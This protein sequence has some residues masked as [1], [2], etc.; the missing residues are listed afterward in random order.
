MNRYIILTLTT[1]FMGCSS[2]SSYPKDAHCAYIPK[3]TGKEIS[4]MGSQGVCGQFIDADTIKID[5][6][7][8]KKINFEGDSYA[9]LYANASSKGKRNVFY[10][11][12]E[13][14]TI[15]TFF[16]DNGADYFHDGLAR[17]IK[18]GKIGFINHDLEVVIEPKYDYARFFENGKARVCNGCTEKKDGEYSMMVGGKWGIIDTTGKLIEPMK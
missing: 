17:V 14:K 4:Q 9:I 16:F 11:T 1:L 6:E 2:S 15:H 7:H 5:P 12:T 3:V 8:L 13:G 18:K 10:V